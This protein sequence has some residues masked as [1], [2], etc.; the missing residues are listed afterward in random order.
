[1]P[2]QWIPRA[3]PKSAWFDSWHTC[4][5]RAKPQWRNTPSQAQGTAA[6]TQP[7]SGLG[8]WPE[9]LQVHG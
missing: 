8:Q 6:P 3:E 7:K 5:N 2:L 4:W 9:T 1:M